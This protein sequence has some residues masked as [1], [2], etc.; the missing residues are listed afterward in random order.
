MTSRRAF[1]GGVSAFLASAKYTPA[2]APKVV[3]M[4]RWQV[5]WLD[6]AFTMSKPFHLCSHCGTG[7]GHII[8]RNDAW[9]ASISH[10]GV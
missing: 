10:P 2:A 4:P 5:R 6:G 8:D 9:L 3:T 1:I 7:L